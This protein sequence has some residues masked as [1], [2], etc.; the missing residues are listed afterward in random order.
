MLE[1]KSVFHVGGSMRTKRS[2]IQV[3]N[4]IRLDRPDLHWFVIKIVKLPIFRV[5]GIDKAEYTPEEFKLLVKSLKV[6]P[7]QDLAN[8]VVLNQGRKKW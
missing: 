3:F 7:F 5:Y 1:N 8:M 4:R 6:K 2:A